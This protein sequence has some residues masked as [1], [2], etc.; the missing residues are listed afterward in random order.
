MAVGVGGKNSGGTALLVDFLRAQTCEVRPGL[1]R[2]LVEVKLFWN[3]W[4][5]QPRWLVRYA[6]V[7]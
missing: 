4:R 7:V 5:R 3:S 2:G 1:R 6:Q